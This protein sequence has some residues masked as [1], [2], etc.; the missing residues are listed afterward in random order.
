[1]YNLAM[2]SP[3]VAE[4]MNYNWPAVGAAYAGYRGLRYA[5]EQTNRYLNRNNT[6]N[7]NNRRNIISQPHTTMP[8][9]FARRAGAKRPFI[10]PV[11]GPRQK[12]RKRAGQYLARRAPYTRPSKGIA[13][14]VV[15]ANCSHMTQFTGTA[16]SGSNIPGTISPQEILN[17]G[18][19]ARYL[20]AYEF[21]KIHSMKVEWIGTYPSFIMS[22]FD[23]TDD[24]QGTTHELE[25]FFERQTSLRLHRSDRNGRGIIGRTQQLSG[26]N[27]F[28]DYISTGGTALATHLENAANKCAIR[29]LSVNNSNNSQKLSGF[30]SF[31]VSFYGMKD[32]SA[33]LDSNQ[34][35]NV[36]VE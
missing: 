7:R 28:K 4:A 12:F 11:A 32:T 6:R 21:V 33:A 24:V 3:Y 35:I 29:F 5:H 1:M 36:V 30:V 16:T 23:T 9:M 15:Y 22:M 19:M 25:P 27:A 20:N 8:A 2:T 10:G 26:L 18:K 34:Q 17:C 31:K 13:S 14:G